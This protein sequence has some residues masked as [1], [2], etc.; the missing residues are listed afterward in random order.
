MRTTP[1]PIVDIPTLS[2]EPSGFKFG[3]EVTVFLPHKAIIGGYTYTQHGHELVLI[4]KI[5][6]VFYQVKA[7][8]IEQLKNLEG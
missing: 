6:K 8:E 3:Q 5:D 4:V 7:S 2:G 1:E